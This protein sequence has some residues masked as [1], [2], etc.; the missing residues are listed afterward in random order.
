MK[1]LHVVTPL[2]MYRNA[3]CGDRR[4]LEA[5][6]RPNDG[7]KLNKYRAVMLIDVIYSIS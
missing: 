5:N 1:I 7:S 2:N 3:S 6:G 4:R